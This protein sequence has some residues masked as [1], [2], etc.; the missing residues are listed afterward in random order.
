[1]FVI[2]AD[3]IAS[4][5]DRDRVADALTRIQARAGGRLP[6]PPERTAGDELQVLAPD[7]STA[8]EIL[9]ELLR[10][11]H[12]RDGLGIGSVSMPLPPSIRE[13]SGPAF[14]AA[15]QAV[16][17]GARASSRFAAAGTGSADAAAADVHALITLLLVG[18]ARWSLQAWEL[19]DLL[20][21]GHTQ[22]SAAAELGITPQ[23]T[24]KRARAAALTVDGDARAAIA[25]VMQSADPEPSRLG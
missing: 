16:Q 24:S 23:A 14:I 25:R 12:F 11:G 10:D 17:R 1:M 15:R 9:L 13:A 8:L 4:R 7:A 6:L 20:E 5:T 21:A 3:Q 18:R 2:I 19:Y 22:A